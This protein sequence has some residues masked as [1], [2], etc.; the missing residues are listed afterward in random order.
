MTDVPLWFKHA[1]S[2]APDRRSVEVD[3]V[4]I[5]YRAWGEPGRP[6]AV[7]V[8]G[9]AAHA[10]WWDHVGPHLAADRR[11]VA[12]D[13]SGHGDSGRREEYSLETWAR[14]VLAVGAAE[15]SGKPVILGHSMGGF[16]ALTAAREHGPQLLGVA[17]IDS[18]VRAE[19]PEM[20]EWKRS[21]SSLARV[22]TYPDRASVVARFR[23][24]PD[25]GGVLPYVGDHVAEASV[26]EVAGG[27]T[28][29]FDPLIFLSSQMTPDTLT[30]AECEVALIRGEYGLATTDMVADIN[31]R[32]GGNVPVTVIPDAGHHIML[33]QPVALIAVLQT[34]LGQWRPR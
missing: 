33:D 16:V 8:H 10:G 11:V 23:P 18:P 3:G 32:M 31:S 12:L 5:D 27:F 29:K 30:L 21:R 9:G 26:R 28:W 24:L 34:L 17:A 20:L 25:S 1:I 15:G 7:L 14:E 2:T 22:K 19:P 13:L 6:V 4:T